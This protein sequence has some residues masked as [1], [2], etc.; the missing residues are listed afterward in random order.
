[1]STL[2]I[3]QAVRAILTTPDHAILLVRIEFPT[4]TVWVLPGGGLDP[5]EDHLTALHRELH[6]EVGLV[7][8]DIGP[9]VWTREQIVEFVDGDYDGQRDQYHHVPVATRFEPAPSMSW[10][11]LRAE[12]MHEIRWW[13]IDQIDEATASGV[14]FA[15][16]RLGELVR[17]LATE[18]IPTAP[19]DTGV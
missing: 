17:R 3:R 15:P 10:E 19:I 1:M 8:M 7:D 2:R 11:D 4:E 6:E 5:G 18:G 13:T 9:H 12:R 16:G 14:R